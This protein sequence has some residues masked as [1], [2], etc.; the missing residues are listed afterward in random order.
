MFRKSIVLKLLVVLIS[1]SMFLSGCGS[2]GGTDKEKSNWEYEKQINEPIKGMSGEEDLV[3]GN[4]DENKVEVFIP[5]GAFLEPTEVT[6]INPD[7]IASY[8][9]DEMEGLGAPIA[10]VAGEGAVRLEQA[11]RITMKYD[12]TILE[13]DYESGELYMGYYN[14]SEW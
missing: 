14:G 6:L 11:V 12:P 5:A 1:I 10:I 13:E 7:T 4:L 3:L 9:E 2:S 8:K